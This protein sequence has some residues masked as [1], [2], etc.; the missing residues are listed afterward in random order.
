MW[1]L[2]LSGVF[3]GLGETNLS[4]DEA[5]VAFENR[6]CFRTFYEPWVPNAI[7]DPHFTLTLLRPNNLGSRCHDRRFGGGGEHAEPS[8]PCRGAR[9]RQGQRRRTKRGTQLHCGPAPGVRLHDER[10]R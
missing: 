1:G 2:P 4:I 5:R 10:G 6:S 3:F 9:M 8:E 7:H